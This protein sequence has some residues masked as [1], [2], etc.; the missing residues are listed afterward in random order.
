MAIVIATAQALEERFKAL[1]SDFDRL[2]PF[3]KIPKDIRSDL[4]DLLFQWSDAYETKDWGSIFLTTPTKGRP[5]TESE[6]DYWNGIYLRA[7]KLLKQAAAAPGVRILTETKPTAPTGPVIKPDEELVTAPIP[8]FWLVGSVAALGFVVWALG[9]KKEPVLAGTEEQHTAKLERI[10]N[11]LKRNLA[12]AR[13]STAPYQE[14]EYVRRARRLYEKAK[15][16]AGWA[17]S[18]SQAHHNFM[19]AHDLFFQSSD[20]QVRKAVRDASC[21]ERVLGRFSGSMKQH[22]Q[23]YRDHLRWAEKFIKRAERSS[24]SKQMQHELHMAYGFLQQALAE[25]E[26][27]GKNFKLDRYWHLQNRYSDLLTKAGGFGHF[28]LNGSNS[29]SR[30]ITTQKKFREALRQA[31]LRDPKFRKE[32]EKLVQKHIEIRTRTYN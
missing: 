16:E 23:G 12:L 2:E 21:S 22:Q 30:P 29:T 13:S 32:Y 14:K 19:K 9:R 5:W 17:S 26:W 25:Q 31:V 6:R 15:C 7:D 11:E 27:V 20:D 10:M 28:G 18:L 1:S 8:W 4:M 3:E 24:S